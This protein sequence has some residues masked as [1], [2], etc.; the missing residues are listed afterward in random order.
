MPS[1]PWEDHKTYFDLYD[2]EVEAEVGPIE[3][4]MDDEV[5]VADA[6]ER[7]ETAQEI[8]EKSLRSNNSFR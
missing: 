8:L 2:T 7:R 6:E 4:E 1:T 3:V 5:C